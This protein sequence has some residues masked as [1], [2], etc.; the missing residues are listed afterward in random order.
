MKDKNIAGILGLF[1]GVFGVHRFYLGQ[2][3]L[4]VLYLVFFWTG[5]TALIGLIDAIVF[6][7][8]DRDEF[9]MKYNRH[10]VYPDHRRYDTDFTREE[11]RQYRAEQRELRQQRRVQRRQQQQAPPRQKTTYQPPVRKAAP[12]SRINN[13]FKSS[14]IQKYREFDYDGAIEDFKKA[15]LIQSTDVAVHFNLACAYSLTEERENAFFHLS[16][17]VEFGFVDFKKIQE[18]DALAYLRIQDEFEIFKKNGYRLNVPPPTAIPPMP[19][20]QPEEPKAIE[21]PQEDL[22]SKNSLLLDQIK[23][24]GELREKGLL[25]EEEFEIQKRKL[26]G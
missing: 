7:S 24:L 19:K 25:T 4:G 14:G 5:I 12:T 10:H 8:M 3:G 9:D 6:L 16:K 1:F 22:L 23:R 13:P 11:R 17:A 15:L 21:E 18:H 20:P 2:T 26:L